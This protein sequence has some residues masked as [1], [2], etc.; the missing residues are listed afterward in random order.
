MKL[1]LRCSKIIDPV[2][3]LHIH[4]MEHT[5]IPDETNHTPIIRVM[6][7]ARDGKVNINK[8]EVGETDSREEHA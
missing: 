2:H 3:C 4:A 7:I 6:T 1:E 5:K 8:Y